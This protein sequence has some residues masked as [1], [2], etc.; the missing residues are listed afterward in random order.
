MI[1]RLTKKNDVLNFL[2]KQPPETLAKLIWQL[3]TGDK[4]TL[5]EKI[6][7][8][9]VLFESAKELWPKEEYFNYPRQ[10]HAVIKECLSDVEK[11]FVVAT[12]ILQKAI[13]Q[14][15]TLKRFGEE[16]TTEI[17]ENEKVR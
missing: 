9:K 4:L 1:D 11:R 3:V 16:L 6:A 2:K 14:V 13:D 8:S 12:D 15:N 7:C 17:A 10:A 5:N